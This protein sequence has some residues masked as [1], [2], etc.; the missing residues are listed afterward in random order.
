MK[1]DRQHSDR[2]DVTLL[3]AA[4]IVLLLLSIAERALTRPFAAHSATAAAVR[5]DPFYHTVSISRGNLGSAAARDDESRRRVLADFVSS[6]ADYFGLADGT[7][8][9]RPA[10]ADASLYVDAGT[11]PL[12]LVTLRSE[13]APSSR[14]TVIAG[15]FDSSSGELRMVSGRRSE[16]D[17]GVV[18]ADGT[19]ARER[20]DHSAGSVRFGL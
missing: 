19:Y 17:C 16:I 12:I 3:G 14:A 1:A 9:L 11:S 4:V 10:A 5:V 20:A 13:C 8:R 18:V 6:H 2:A 7:E 15:A